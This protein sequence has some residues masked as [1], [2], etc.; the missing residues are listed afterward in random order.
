MSKAHGE[1]PQIKL[2]STSETFSGLHKPTYFNQELRFNQPGNL[3]YKAGGGKI[4]LY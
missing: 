2:R 4:N 1:N 3:I